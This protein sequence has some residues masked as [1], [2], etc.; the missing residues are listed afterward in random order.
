MKGS[1]SFALRPGARFGGADAA[2]AL[3]VV[4]IVVMMIVPLPTWLLD[5]LIAANLSAAVAILL[6]VLTSQTLSPS[7]RSRLSSCSP[8]ST[9]SVSTSRP[10]DSFFSKPTPARSMDGAMKLVKGEVRLR[11]HGT[12]LTRGVSP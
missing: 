4:S 3:L 6:V 5:I 12:R 1:P 8:R 10:R 11:S 2:L 9:G 7:R